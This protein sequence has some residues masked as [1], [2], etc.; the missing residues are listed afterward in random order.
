MSE[1]R[2]Q[3]NKEGRL[4][5]LGVDAEEY[6]GELPEARSRLCVCR[7]SFLMTFVTSGIS[8]AGSRQSSIAPNAVE[9]REAPPNTTV[10]VSSQRHPEQLPEVLVVP[11]EKT[12]TCREPAR[13]IPLVTKVMRKGARHTQRR[14]R[15]SGVP[16]D[17]LEHLP[18]KK[19][20]SA[21]FIALCSH[22]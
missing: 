14:D 8:L 17:I 18:P 5:F 2:E 7:D 9:S 20:E 1:V 3:S 19:P 15:A 13:D 10:S 12:P 22:L 4:W 16:P 6:T 21:Y 11:R